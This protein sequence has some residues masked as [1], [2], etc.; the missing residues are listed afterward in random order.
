MTP[1]TKTIFDNLCFSAIAFSL[2]QFYLGLDGIETYIEKNPDA[3]T[4]DIGIG[5]ILALVIFGLFR[6]II[7]WFFMSRYN[8][9]IAGYLMVMDVAYTTYQSCFDQGQLFTWTIYQ[10]M[11]QV[12]IIVLSIASLIVFFFGDSKFL[13]QQSHD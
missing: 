2:V 8:S 3:A 9:R 7:I 13:R 5:T 4:L 11:I 6:Y 1:Q 12:I 10:A